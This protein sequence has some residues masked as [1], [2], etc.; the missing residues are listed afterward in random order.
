MHSPVKSSHDGYGCADPLEIHSEAAAGASAEHLSRFWAESRYL[1]QPFGSLRLGF[2]A[3]RMVFCR[4]LELFGAQEEVQKSRA[5]PL[6]PPVQR[7][8]QDLSLRSLAM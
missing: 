6:Y 2:G 8:P 4:Y 1:R 5:K 3:K 7:R